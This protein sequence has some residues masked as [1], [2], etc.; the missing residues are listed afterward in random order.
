MT[1]KDY[2]EIITHHYRQVAKKE[3]LKP[4]STMADTITREKETKALL[5]YVGYHLA[6]SRGGSPVQ[7]L[8]VGCGNGY[9][10]EILSN[11]FPSALYIGVEKSEEL[12][13]LAESR[14]Q[15]KE[16]IT[17]IPGDIRDNDFTVGQLADI[18]ICQRVLINLLD[19]G[20]QKS[21]LENLIRAV[22]KPNSGRPGGI[23]IFFEAF[24]SALENLNTARDEINLPPIEPAH[25][26]LYLE[27]G[28]F[29]N[30]KLKPYSAGSD[31]NPPNFLSTHYF[32]TRVLHPVY[33]QDRPFKRNSEFVKFFSGALKDN[34]GD[35][36]PLKLYVFNRVS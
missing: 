31:L 33:L 9:T 23:L 34:T 22:K 5:D 18:L 19:K 28:F 32:V 10:L 6:G 27:E 26:N 35:Y 1:E 25:H 21:A 36:S 7:I 16:N 14:F 11:Q 13:E 2:D 24:S 20:D 30:P 29:D 12:R 8:D 4:T 3:G 15:K 17:I